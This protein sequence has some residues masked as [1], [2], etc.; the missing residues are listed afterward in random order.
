MEFR[1]AMARLVTVGV[2]C[3][4]ITFTGAF[5]ILFPES[6]EGF[7]VSAMPE[8]TEKKENVTE[9]EEVAAS[10][11]SEAVAVPESDAPE[12]S[13]ESVPAMSQGNVLGKVIERFITPYTANTSYNNVYIK[14]STGLNIDIKGLL[15]SPLSYKI[16]K[17][18]SPQVLIMH[19]HTTESFMTEDRDYYTD[20][21]LSRTTDSSKNMINLGN[22]VADKLNSAGITTLHDTTLHDY[23]AYSGSY[24]R[25][26]KTVTSYLKKYPSIKIVLDLH[27][28]A[29]AQNDTDKVKIT[30]EIEGRKAAQ[31]MLVMGAQ[32]G[33]VKN[34]P[35]WKE[36]LK[37][38][39][40]LQQNL[41]VMYPSLAR[42]ISLVSKNYNQ[43]L[44]SGSML[45]EI[46]TDGNTLEEVSYSAELLG[47]ALVSTFNSIG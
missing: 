15:S 16:E 7:S 12:G 45:I 21:D 37:L 2:L 25:S 30:A 22:I 11:S 46:G 39:I 1:F 44:S 20:L 5:N 32:S 47:N 43:S 35:N 6:R 42:S 17:N 4:A 9:S 40:R 31:V 28:D 38:A 19:T 29:I 24:N 8:F 26:A 13:A 3:I 10:Q 23:P 33:S 41:E 36:N 27:R 34:F 18:N 14:N